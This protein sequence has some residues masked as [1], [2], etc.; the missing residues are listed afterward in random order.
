M[1]WG[2]PDAPVPASTQDSLRGAGHVRGRLIFHD[3]PLLVLGVGGGRPQTLNGPEIERRFVDMKFPIISSIP[4]EG[5]DGFIAHLDPAFLCFRAGQ[6]SSNVVNPNP[7][8]VVDR[9]AADKERMLRHFL[10]DHANIELRQ[11]RIQ[12][13]Y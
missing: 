7:N 2:S 9:P 3:P 6:R 4:D 12:A 11:A 10:K 1:A 13:G 5:S 8:E